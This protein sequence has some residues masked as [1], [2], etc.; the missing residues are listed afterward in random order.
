VHTAGEGVLAGHAEIGVVVEVGY[1]QRGVDAIDRLG[2]GGEELLL[3]FR[4][5][6]AALLQGEFF[7]LVLSSRMSLSLSRSY[8]GAS[9]GWGNAAELH[10]EVI[11]TEAAQSIESKGLNW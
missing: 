11:I 4:Q 3:A 2:G 9:G 6:A 7:P 8:N 5:P 1:V 10:R